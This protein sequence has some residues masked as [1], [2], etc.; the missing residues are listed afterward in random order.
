MPISWFP[1]N[2]VLSIK[3][4]KNSLTKQLMLRLGQNLGESILCEKTNEML[5]TKKDTARQWMRLPLT[6]LGTNGESK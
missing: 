2:T 4:N 3:R 5:R 1:I 6:K